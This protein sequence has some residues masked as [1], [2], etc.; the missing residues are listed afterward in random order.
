M[1]TTFFAGHKLIVLDI[2]LKASKFNWPYFVDYI[3]PDLNREK[4]N[5]HR[6]IPQATFWRIWTIQCATMGQNWHQKSGS[7]MF[8]DYHTHPVRQI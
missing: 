8:H 2:L 6:Q 4:L 5:F 1:I 7:I 3:F